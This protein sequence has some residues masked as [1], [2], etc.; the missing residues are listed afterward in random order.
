MYLS[1]IYFVKHAYT[2]RSEVTATNENKYVFIIKCMYI[3][4]IL[5]LKLQLKYED[6]RCNV[7]Y[8]I[9]PLEAMNNEAKQITCY[10]NS[11]LFP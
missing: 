7:H 2:A 9:S 6:K 4:G 3:V 1:G 11:K 8:K 10:K 5:Q